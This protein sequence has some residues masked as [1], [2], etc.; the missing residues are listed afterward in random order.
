VPQRSHRLVGSGLCY[1]E[2]VCFQEFELLFRH[3]RLSKAGLLSTR[4]SHPA[5]VTSPR[6]RPC[7]FHP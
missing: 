1:S 7:R 2:P 6:Q 4:R 5:P 3:D